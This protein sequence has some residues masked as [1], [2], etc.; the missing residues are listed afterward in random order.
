MRKTLK[1][2][3]F[4]AAAMALVLSACSGAAPAPTA[5]PAAPAKPAATAEPITIEYW[6]YNFASRIEAM[7]DLIKQFEAENPGIKV[8]HNSEIPYDNFIDKVAASAPAGVGPDVVTL[9]NGWVPSWVNA[10]YLIPLPEKDFPPADLEKNFSAMILGTKFQGKYWTVPTAV[11]ALALFWN[12]DHFK[13]AGLDPEKPPATLDEFVDY[14]K[15]LT[16]R[17]GD[18]ITQQGFAVEMTGQ[19][20][21]W[22]R[23]VLSRQYGA[24]PFTPDNKT[25]GYGDAK[26]CQAFKWLL[27]FETDLKT[28]SNDLFD[29]ATTAFQNGKESMH[30]DG[31]FRLGALA[32]KPELNWGVAPLPTKDGI[33]ANFGSFWTHGITKK[34][35]SD[36][37]RLEAA[38]KFLKFIT[39]P[40]AG[41]AWVKKTG[42]LPAQLS[43]AADPDLAKDPKY[44]AFA[45]QLAYSYATFFVDEAKQRKNLIDAFDAVR[46]QKAD[47][48]AA[49]ADAVKKDQALYDEFWA[50]NK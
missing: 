25:L 7:N 28:G 32:S 5:A 14:A 16:K 38:T 29:G 10:G 15:K 33:K 22:F 11:R 19:A 39:T 9:F 45:K 3:A 31:S 13:A 50:K 2:L 37:K 17:D 6:Q 23:E 43:A 30:I 47:P 1:S 44:G 8:V 12:K 24:T 41:L 20:H 42:E 36:P 27:A 40:A 49:L 21:Q 26:S 35:G 4:G 48:C 34:G 46:L 18:K